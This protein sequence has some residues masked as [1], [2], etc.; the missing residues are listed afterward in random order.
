[1][2]KTWGKKDVIIH[3]VLSK[4][5][6][7]PLQLSKL[8]MIAGLSSVEGKCYEDVNVK[9]HFFIIATSSRKEFGNK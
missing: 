1:M 2:L 6:I 5:L 8:E 7:F 9:Y 3:V 4:S